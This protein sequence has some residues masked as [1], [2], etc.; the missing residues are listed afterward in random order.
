MLG[1]VLGDI[2]GSIWEGGSCT[3][4]DKNLL[5]FGCDFT[6]D[7]VCTIAIAQAL[8]EEL[9]VAETLRHWVRRYPNRGYGGKFYTWAH[10]D[11]QGPYGSFANGAAMRVSPVG[12]L[13]KSATEA[14]TL[15]TLTA[16]VT[17][18]HPEGIRGAQAIALAIWLARQG[19]SAADIRLEI[20]HKVGYAL[21]QSMAQLA[22]PEAYGFSVLAE[23]TV[24]EALTAALEADSFEAAMKNALCIGGDTDTIACMAGGMA[25][26][27]FGIP[28]ALVEASKEYVDADMQSVLDRLYAC[29]GQS[30]PRIALES[31]TARPAPQQGLLYSLK[32]MFGRG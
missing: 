9:D 1:A 14:L 3:N 17:H 18:N 24:P 25:E 27:L 23:E 20:Q 26:A 5:G 29:N 11:T 28:K 8:V 21:N 13:A 30:G 31:S 7:S 2:I 10:S 16:E 19:H 4:P 6:D 15:A 22:A 32:K 12:F